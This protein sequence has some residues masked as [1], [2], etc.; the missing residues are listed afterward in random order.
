MDNS[1]LDCRNKMMF[2]RS[3]ESLIQLL[4]I[5]VA[6]SVSHQSESNE[7]VNQK[8][9][10]N[11]RLSNK[12]KSC[13]N[14]MDCP[15]WT[16]CNNTKCKCKPNIKNHYTIKC[17][18]ATLQLSVIR[19]HCVTYNNMT[20]ELVEGNCFKNCKNG[21]EKVCTFRCQKIYPN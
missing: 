5:T 19:C 14:D 1:K 13:N 9:A 7:N 10:Q 21:R 15:P 6:I 16:E 20:D 4:L 11:K 3:S 18:K 12:Q 2:Y 8:M 17:N